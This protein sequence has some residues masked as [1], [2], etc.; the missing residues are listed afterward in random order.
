MPKLPGSSNT[1]NTLVKQKD[2]L[3]ADFAIKNPFV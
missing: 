2:L 1:F 3:V